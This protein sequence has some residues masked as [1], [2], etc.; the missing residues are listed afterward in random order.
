MKVAVWD[1]YVTR[2]N[3]LVMHFDIIVP[4]DQ[5]DSEAIL[6]IGRRYLKTMGEEGQP[7]TTEE[8]KFCHLQDARPQWVESIKEFGFFIYEMENCS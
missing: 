1:T 5:H 6:G 8:C 3:G 2:K 7:L 4:E